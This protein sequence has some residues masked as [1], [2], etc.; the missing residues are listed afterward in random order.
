MF[1]TENAGTTHQPVE[2]LYPFLDLR[3]VNYLLALPPFPWFFQKTLLR[4]AMVGQLPEKIRTRKKTPLQ[5]DP[6]VQRFQQD[7]GA[8]PNLPPWSG[9]MDR[10]INRSQLLPPRGTLNSEQVSQDARP[11]CFNF[12]LQTSRRVQ[13]K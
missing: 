2:V 4:K 1:E 11:H 7:G 13:Y 3:L 6:L 9:Q 5:G 12:W 8:W 10:Y